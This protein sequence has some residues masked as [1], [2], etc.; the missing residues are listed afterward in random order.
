MVGG[1][2]L[3]SGERLPPLRSYMDDVTSILQTAP[4]TIRLLE[5][6]DELLTW[7]RMKVKSGRSRNLSLRKGVLQAR[8]TFVA[9][10]EPIPQLD[11]KPLQSLGRQ[12]SADLTDKEMV[13]QAR[14][15]CLRSIV[16]AP[17]ISGC[18]CLQGCPYC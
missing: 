4:C 14:Q 6:L 13:K 2:K 9:G 1:I 16:A 15:H 10:G 12:Y 17:A 8:T 11:E 7:A 3:R 5:R 18:S